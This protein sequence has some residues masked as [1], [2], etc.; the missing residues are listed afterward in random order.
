MSTEL[1]TILDNLADGVT[2]NPSAA[3][4]KFGADSELTGVCEVDVRIG[5][6]TVKVDEPESLGGGGVAPNPVEYALLAL[7]SCWAITY[8]FWA[9]KLGMQIDTCRVD[10]RGDLDVRGVFGL[11]ENVR[12]GYTGVR[13]DVTLGGPESPAS[14]EM[15]AEAVEDHCPVL[16]IFANATPVTSTLSIAGAVKT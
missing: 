3:G 11:D 9:T 5:T 13:V 14:Y 8:R 6:H 15:L 12:P 2:L 1:K 4:V 16:D 7:G 10:V